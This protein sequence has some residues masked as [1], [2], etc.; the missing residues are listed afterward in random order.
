MKGAKQMVKNFLKNTMKLLGIDDFGKEGKKKQI[1]ILLKQ[2]KK[3]KE[4]L[5]K[6]LDKKLS[7][8]QKKELNTEKEIIKLHIKKG[9]KALDKI[10]D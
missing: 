1:K 7:K 2:L 6:K 9:E 3:K 10:S 5:N 8:S 4:D